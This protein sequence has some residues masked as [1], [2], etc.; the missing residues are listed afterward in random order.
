MKNWMESW[1]LKH[2]STWAMSYPSLLK[3]GK[4]KHEWNENVKS[5]ETIIPTIWF[6]DSLPSIGYVSHPQ[7]TI[8]SIT[9]YNTFVCQ[10]LKPPPL[11]YSL[12]QIRIF[13]LLCLVF[14]S[15]GRI[16]FGAEEKSEKIKLLT[17]YIFMYYIHMYMEQKIFKMPSYENNNFFFRRRILYLHVRALAPFFGASFGTTSYQFLILTLSRWMGFK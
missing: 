12:L 10:N 16:I 15:C 2:T 7:L 1:T 17:A 13:F 11:L 9:I 5:S 3:S 8:L 4:A 6:S 14:G